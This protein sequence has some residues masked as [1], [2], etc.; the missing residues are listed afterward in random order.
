MGV[1]KLAERSEVK[2][3]LK[4][5]VRFFDTMPR[6]FCSM[7]PK[8]LSIPPCSLIFFGPMLPTPCPF[9]PHSPRSLKPPAE[10]HNSYLLTVALNTA[11]TSAGYGTSGY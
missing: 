1:R 10:S 6:I 2:K 9:G 5:C 7:L 4:S 11:I 8:L 3:I